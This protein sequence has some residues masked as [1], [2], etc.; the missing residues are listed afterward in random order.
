MILPSD[1]SVPIVGAPMAGGPTTDALVVAV[2]RA[3]GLGVLATA[4][5]TPHQT[6]ESI[7]AVRG[8]GVDRFGAN[9]FVP[10]DPTSRHGDD[11]ALSDYRE[12]LQ[13]RIPGIEPGVVTPPSTRDYAETVEIVAESAV[14]WV[15]FTFGLPAADVVDR[16]HARGCA[17]VVTVTTARDARAAVDRGADIV[18]VQGPEAGGHRS[19]FDVA[20]DPPTTPLDD[21]LGEVRSAVDVPLV[22]SGG[23]GTGADVRRLLDIGADAVGVGTA[24]LLADEAGTTAPYRAALSDPSFA[25]TVV[26][27]AF[28]GRAARGLRNRFHDDLGAAA[29]ARFPEV[30]TLTGPLR[31]ASTAAG[32][33]QGISLW[34]GTGHSAVREAPAAD[35][36]GGLWADAGGRGPST[37]A[38]ADR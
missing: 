33:P 7:A 29:P 26:T 36:V 34:A 15:S 24:L 38:R 6:A 32:D 16:L 17:V 3:G 10:G 21:L 28:S 19:T 11:T 20:A 30:N 27:R 13:H 5:R 9:L 31:R 14:P 12:L 35:I 4:Y 1:L 23:V 22:A 8:A 25:E 37:G 18:W 2:S